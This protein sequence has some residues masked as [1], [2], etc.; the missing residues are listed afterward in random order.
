MIFTCAFPVLLPA[1]V[2]ELKSVSMFQ[3]MPIIPVAF[4][5][6]VSWH[7]SPLV[8]GLP[9]HDC[10]LGVD[11]H[12]GGFAGFNGTAISAH[13]ISGSDSV[14][15]IVTLDAPGSLLPAPRLSKGALFQRSVWPAPSVTTT[16]FSSMLRTSITTSPDALE[17][18]TVGQEDGINGQKDPE[19]VLLKTV[20]KGL[21]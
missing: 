14:H 12:T 5:I 11:V 8:N 16:L 20:P 4:V 17:T 10:G 19:P 7:S 21:A 6:Q 2:S 1:T 9:T 15:D 18:V 3:L 13:S